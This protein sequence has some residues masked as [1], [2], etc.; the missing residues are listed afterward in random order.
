MMMAINNHSETAIR[1]TGFNKRNKVISKSNPTQIF[2]SKISFQ[3]IK[4]FHKIDRLAEKPLP[5]GVAVRMIPSLPDQTHVE[6]VN[7]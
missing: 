2:I 1:N 6:L 3:S 7:K 5:C 4:S